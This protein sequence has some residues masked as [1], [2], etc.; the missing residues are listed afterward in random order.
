MLQT[1]ISAMTPQLPVISLR[2][3]KG[4][5]VAGKIIE[6]HVDVNVAKA[7]KDHITQVS[8]KFQGAI[9]TKIQT[10]GGRTA[11]AIPLVSSLI[12]SILSQGMPQANTNQT[13]VLTDNV[14][15]V[16]SVLSLWMQGLEFP[17]TG[18][19]V[20]SCPFQFQLPDNAPP[21]FDCKRKLHC[22]G[23]YYSLEVVAER[24]GHFRSPLRIYRRIQVVPAA[25]QAQLL[26]RESMA[27]GWGGPW[28]TITREDKLRHRIWGD[29]SHARATLS[30]PDLPSFPY[31]TPIPFILYIV[32]E[33]E[34]LRL[35]D[36]RLEKNGRTVFPAPPTRS[37]DVILLL[38]R[39]VKIRVRGNGEIRHF[40]DTLDLQTRNFG[41]PGAETIREVVPKRHE[42][43][44]GKSH[45]SSPKSEM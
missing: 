17:D 20:V 15:I 9:V 14:P 16:D 37:S 11:V 39:E 6:G 30:I 45:P 25:S 44:M 2:L 36:L 3:H 5:C 19:H 13:T 28:K 12:S 1:R 32:T 42:R 10:G 24:S 26:V 33:T 23:I 4:P 43:G 29:Y 38:H 34:P 31:D 8:I 27:Q 18:S 21:S 40:K 41:V 7:Q 22:G 35:S